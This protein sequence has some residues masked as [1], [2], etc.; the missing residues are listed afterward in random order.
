MEPE[1]TEAPDPAPGE[2]GETQWL[3]CHDCRRHLAAGPDHDPDAPACP[4]CRGAFVEYAEEYQPPDPARQAE[5][6]LRQHMA[7]I[8]SQFSNILPGIQVSVGMGPDG[9]QGGQ[10]AAG[11][12][13]VGGGQGGFRAPEAFMPMMQQLFQPGGA[14]VSAARLFEDFLNGIGQDINIAELDTRTFHNPAPPEVVAALPKVPMPAP[15]HGE[16]TACSICLADIAVGETCYELPC[17]H[18]FHGES[19]ILEWLKTKDSCP[20]CRR[21]LTATEGN[22]A[23]TN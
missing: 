19:C 13:F 6:A 3:W 18:R 5:E 14:Q 17:S 16:S 2:P 15:E 8:A 9:A 4:S 22:D 21:K 11:F 1:A 12:G 23:G 7:Q 20:V 10:G